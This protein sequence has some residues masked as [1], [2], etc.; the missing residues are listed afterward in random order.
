MPNFLEKT[1]LENPI[2]EEKSILE[3]PI[4]EKTFSGKT[5][6]GKRFLEKLFLDEGGHSD[7]LSLIAI[8]MVPFT[9]AGLISGEWTSGT[10][11]KVADGATSL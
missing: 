4:T 6:F 7:R 3:K 8:L 1:I 11:S 10:T 2:F 5:V 9:H